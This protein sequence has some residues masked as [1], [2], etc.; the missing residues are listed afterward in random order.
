MDE[1]SGGGADAETAA[2]PITAKP[3]QVQN[4]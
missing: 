1:A 2:N 3:R 4:P